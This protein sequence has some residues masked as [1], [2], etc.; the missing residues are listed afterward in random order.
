MASLEK[1]PPSP[2]VATYKHPHLQWATEYLVSRIES[3]SPETIL[4]L[5][6]PSHAGKSTAL[7]LIQH[8]LCERHAAQMA[9]DPAHVPFARANLVWERR[10]GISFKDL[11]TELLASLRE[12]VGLRSPTTTRMD[13][14]T[15]VRRRLR[16]VLNARSSR[17]VILDEGQQFVVGTNAST[18]VENLRA[19]K[20]LAVL[21]QIPILVSAT[22]E[23]LAHV[24]A[25]R[26]IEARVI[27]VHLPPYTDT[28]KDEAHFA[29]A[30]LWAQGKLQE[31]YP[32]FAFDPGKW[33]A[34]RKICG[35]RIGTLMRWLRDAQSDCWSAGGTHLQHWLDVHAP[36]PGRAGRFAAEDLMGL[37]HLGAI[38]SSGSS[39]IFAPKNDA[40]ISPS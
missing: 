39:I 2:F 33:S 30:L 24:P 7:K 21:L 29:G 6:G 11:Y 4:L 9:R 37:N 19:L 13:P 14:T 15:D 38:S 1:K 10:I 26:E 32:G 27:T 5:V 31:R 35:G 3:G 25:A 34:M 36:P 40:A 8:T 16:C 22:Y 28:E 17:V 18:A 23:L 20:N 12:S